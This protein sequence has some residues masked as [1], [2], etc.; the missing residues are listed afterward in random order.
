MQVRV[1]NPQDQEQIN[2]IRAHLKQEQENFVN[3]DFSDPKTLHGENMP[4]L[5]VLSQSQGQFTSEYQDLE[6]GAQLTFKTQKPEIINALHMW[7]MAQMT[8]HGSDAMA[9]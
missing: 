8:D 6:D 4:G 7:F 2:L 5:S 3:A 9:M 1:K